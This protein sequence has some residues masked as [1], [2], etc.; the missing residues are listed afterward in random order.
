MYNVFGSAKLNGID[1]ETELLKPLA[2]I[3]D[4]YHQLG[5]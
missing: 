2:C 4:A 5:H 3:A 1:R